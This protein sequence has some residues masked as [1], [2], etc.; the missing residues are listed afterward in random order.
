[1]A[2]TTTF[3]PAKFRVSI[4][5]MIF[6]WL[7][8]ALGDNVFDITTNTTKDGDLEKLPKPI[9]EYKVNSQSSRSTGAGALNREAVF[10]NVTITI[11]FKVRSQVEELEVDLLDD[12]L[13]AYMQSSDSTKG[14]KALGVAGLRNGL[15]TGPMDNNSKIYYLHRWILSVRPLTQGVAP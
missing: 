3:D 10:K 1:M 2:I 12:I 6:E 15:L 5:E 14:R 11:G 8:D 13:L 4:Q 9:C 7:T